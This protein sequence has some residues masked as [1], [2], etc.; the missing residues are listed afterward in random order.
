MIT[1]KLKNRFIS[2]AA[3]IILGKSAQTEPNKAFVKNDTADFAFQV[4]PAGIRAGKKLGIFV[5]LG[6][7]HRGIISAGL[8][9][10]F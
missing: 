4:N 5:E 6:Y 7:G 3:G 9:Y 8:N 10:K 2:F 1:T